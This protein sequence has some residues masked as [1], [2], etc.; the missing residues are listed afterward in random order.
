[1]LIHLRFVSKIAHN[2]PYNILKQLSQLVF[3]WYGAFVC[4][5]KDDKTKFSWKVLNGEQQIVGVMAPLWWMSHWCAPTPLCSDRSGG[6]RTHDEQDWSNAVGI[7]A[8]SVVPWCQ[9]FQ[10]GRYLATLGHHFSSRGTG[11]RSIRRNVQQYSYECK[12]FMVSHC[13]GALCTLIY[14]KFTVSQLHYLATHQVKQ[15]SIT[16]TLMRH[17]R[18]FCDRAHFN[19]L[20]PTQNCRNLADDISN[21]FSWTKMHEFRLRFR[22]SLLFQV[23]INNI[24]TLLPIMA[25][26]RPGDKPLSEPMM[27]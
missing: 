19:L 11:T 21:V 23:V 12:S 7:I 18:S 13:H 16:L 8:N 15:Q 2:F 4:S 25:W 24:A 9:P 22:R 10:G 17:F 1:M 6:F 14:G 3:I 20:R 5:M 26:R 27:A